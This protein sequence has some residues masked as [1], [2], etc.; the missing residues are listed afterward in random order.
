[1]N[2]NNNKNNEIEN[3][4]VQREKTHTHTPKMNK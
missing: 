3:G 2:N 1:M 4:T